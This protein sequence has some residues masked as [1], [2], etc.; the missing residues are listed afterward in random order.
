MSGSKNHLRT[1]RPHSHFLIY[2]KMTSVQIAQK[3]K[4]KSIQK[5]MRSRYRRY[6]SKGIGGRSPNKQ[7]SQTGSCLHCLRICEPVQVYTACQRVRIPEISVYLRHLQKNLP[8]FTQKW[9]R[10]YFFLLRAEL[11][12]SCTIDLFPSWAQVKCFHKVASS[13]KWYHF[14]YFCKTDFQPFYKNACRW[15][16]PEPLWTSTALM[17]ARSFWTLYLSSLISKDR[18][19]SDE[20]KSIQ[21]LQQIGISSGVSDC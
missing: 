17:A 16:I 21:L 19:T 14:A 11:A 7:N 10:F 12:R 5:W 9:R 18:C 2:L 6:R 3:S 13:A 4:M 20:S 8:H 15:S 1:I